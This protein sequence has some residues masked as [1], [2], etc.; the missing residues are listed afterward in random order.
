VPIVYL[1]YGPLV[2]KVLGDPPRPTARRFVAGAMPDVVAAN[3][4]E[5]GFVVKN[6]ATDDT[7]S[8]IDE[9]LHAQ[10]LDTLTTATPGILVLLSGD[11]NTN[12]G[13]SS[14]ARCVVTAVRLGWQVELYCWRHS[15]SSFFMAAESLA[16]GRIRLQFLD[17]WRDEVSV[18]TSR[19]RSREHERRRAFMSK[20]GASLP[21]PA[22]AF[23]RREPERSL[24]EVLLMVQDTVLRCTLESG[25]HGV[26]SSAFKSRFL[27]LQGTQLQLCFDGVTLKV[28]DLM[29]MSAHCVET[30]T[31]NTQPVYKTK[32]GLK[33][34]KATLGHD[35][36][37]CTAASVG[38]GAGVSNT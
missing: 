20:M 10:I 6:G 34:V 37:K 29:D 16:R 8:H 18:A 33:A 32:G 36:E 26:L 11:G 35:T 5:Q 4:R 1:R 19:M 9:L 30:R 31:I 14:F 28:K 21:E 7:G 27:E 22:P 15:T 13:R 2:A 17:E 23:C 25:G 38:A 12:G 3:W 24:E